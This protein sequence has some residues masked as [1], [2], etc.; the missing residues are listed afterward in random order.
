[1]LAKYFKF[2][3]LKIYNMWYDILYIYIYIHIYVSHAVGEGKLETK[4]AC[5]NLMTV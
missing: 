1:M 2:A 4:Q 5:N 3:K